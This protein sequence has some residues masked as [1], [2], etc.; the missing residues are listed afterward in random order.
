MIS[1]WDQLVG[2]NIWDQKELFED[3]GIKRDPRELLVFIYF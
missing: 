2:P 3:L 1:I